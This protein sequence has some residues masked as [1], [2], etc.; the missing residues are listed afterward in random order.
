[1]HF[2]K[3]VSEQKKHGDDCPC[4]SGHHEV[5]E[6]SE[7]GIYIGKQ[8]HR[9]DFLKASG[10]VTAGLLL[11]PDLAHAMNSRDRIVMLTN[12]HTGEKLRTM[13]WTPEDGYIRESLDSVSHFMRDFR[14]NQIKPVDPKLLDILHAI[15]LNIG[16][17]AKIQVTSGYRSPKTNRMLRRRSKNVAKKSYHMKGQAADFQVKGYSGK[18]LRNIALALRSGGVGYYPGAKYIHVDSG[19]VRTWTYK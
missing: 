14:L 7:G 1:M 12:T 18:S 17:T 8:L 11:G 19:P 9:R 10:V 3:E 2:L 16:R 5:A 13:Y 15:N 6:Y 4:C